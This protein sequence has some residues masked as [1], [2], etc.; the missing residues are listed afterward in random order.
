M[1]RR[2][3]GAARRLPKAGDRR[4]SPSALAASTSSAKNGLPSEQATADTARAEATRPRAL[5]PDQ[6]A[7]QIAAKRAAD[8]AARQVAAERARRLGTTPEEP[9]T[10]RDSRRDGPELRL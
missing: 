10:T 7:R 6:A 8:V 4:P 2:H 3:R 9:A 1:L 5:L